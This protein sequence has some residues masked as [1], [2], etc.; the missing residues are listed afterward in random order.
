MPHPGLEKSYDPSQVESRWY[1]DW[2]SRGLFT[3]QPDPARKPFTVV[4]PPPNVTGRLTM[5]HVLNNSLQDV[6][7][8]WKRMEGYNTLWLPG[9]DHAGIAT[10]NVVERFLK[11]R[12]TSKEELGR[13]RF[14]EEVWR[15]KREYGGEIQEDLRLLGCSLDWSR[16]RFTMDE[17]LSR[18]VREVFV[19]L[20][21]KGLV[22]RGSYVVNWCPRCLTALSDEEVDRE[23]RPGKLYYLKYPIAGTKEKFVTVA[24][25]RPETLLGD[26]AVA[27]HP[28]D[29]RYT[30]LRGKTA[31]LPIVRREIPILADEYVDP[32]F[33]TGALKIT[34]AHDAND[35]WVGQRHGLEPIN[36]MNPDATM[37]ENAADYA[38]MDR[39]DARER[40][41]AALTDRGLVAR[42]EPYDLSPGE[43]SRCHTPIEPRLSSQ[44][45]VKMKPL[46]EPALQAHRRGQ[47]KFYPK[48]WNKVY[49]NWMDNVRDWCISRQLW[50]GHRIPVWYCGCGEMA[51]DTQAPQACPKCGSAELRQDEDVLDTWFSSWLWP[52]STLG[53]PEPT[54][55]LAYFYP[56]SFLVTAA[57]IIF[58][59]VA[60]MIMA[61]L[62]FMGEVPFT[63][64]FYNSIVRDAQGR[65]M[66][67]S[68]GNSPDPELLIRKHGADA[69]RFTMLSLTPTGQDLLF[70]EA[71][72]DQG[73]FFANK[74]WNATRLVLM[75]TEGFEPARVRESHLKLSLADRWILDRRNEAIKDVSR[76]LK[77]FRFNDAANAVYHFLWH[78]YCDWYLEL[79]KPA[80]AQGGAA[81]LAARW[82]A[83]RVLDDT[84]RLLHPFM[85]FLSEELWQALPGRREG[86]RL[87]VAAWPRQRTAH[88]RPEAV[89]EMQELQEVI[90]AIRTLRSEMSVPPG[91]PVKV[92]VHAPQAA[93][94]RLQASAPL[95]RALCRAESVDI[96]EAVSKP[97][98][99]ASAVA[100]GCEIYLPLAGLIDL[101]AE[102]DRLARELERVEGL[103][104]VARKKLSN[105][106]FLTKAK[107]DVVERERSK[108]EELAG[109]LEKVERA[110]KAIG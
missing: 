107:P 110:L 34:P 55:D 99:C 102:K 28:R 43:C 70:E 20:Y 32:K 67:K 35:F 27:V 31:I 97:E 88:R 39:F 109:V 21:R 83:V 106:D 3:P 29:R 73:R 17:G 25:T 74:V 50:W 22:Y 103:L 26:V 41:V 37:N 76:C 10:Q 92:L 46:A 18:A 30:S 6:V 47:V 81:A 77:T 65:K 86:E 36:V 93:A 89:R 44:W 101:T 52:F 100:A 12:G 54:A 72:I 62:E 58:F 13:E 79:A 1:A 45:F 82:T 11:E 63:H 15:W 75:H 98:A 59:W 68:L 104:L 19:R 87:P 85:P 66:S 38:G 5:G 23:S 2:V 108:V 33:G 4:I 56:T 16:E 48:R 69:V 94:A 8:R 64:V 78:E 49:V 57:D 53:W 91:L 40:I 95:I 96:G 51:V 24:T 84:L 71:K 61:G 60:R 14:L 9:M 80:F 90:T 105:Q 42:V 7:V